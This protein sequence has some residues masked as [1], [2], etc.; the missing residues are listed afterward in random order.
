MAVLQAIGNFFKKIWNWIKETAWIQPLL[1]VGLIFG[2]IFSIP[3]IVKGINELAA[4]Q[5]NAINFYYN[6]QESLVGKENSGAYKLTNN[7]YEKMSDSSITSE[8][9]EKF[10]L[11]FV[12]S[13]CSTCEEVKGGFDALKNNFDGSLQP[14]DKLPFKMY[15]IFTDEVTG[16]TDDDKT[17]FVKYLEDFSYFFEEVGDIARNSNYFVNGKISTTDIEYLEST[18][19]D[20]FLT[21]T[22]LLVDFTDDSSEYGVSEVMFGVTG[23]NDFK[24]AELL[25]DC[26]N[27]D[28]DF[29]NK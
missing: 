14:N 17:A 6:Y 23:D 10:F 29:G 7:V 27:H 19:P 8:Y 25:L 26:W 5:E 16:D 4:N 20:N 21:P 2:V 3:S 18:D 24:K 13:E 1:I 12:S 22:I 11:A 15:T 9:G 28:G